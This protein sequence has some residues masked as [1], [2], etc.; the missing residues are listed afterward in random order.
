MDLRGFGMVSSPQLLGMS[1][2]LSMQTPP[3]PSADIPDP[4]GR[5]AISN[6][7]HT[8]LALLRGPER[9]H[10][11]ATFCAPPPVF[12][13]ESGEALNHRKESCERVTASLKAAP[14][15]AGLWLR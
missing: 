3:S 14:A 8:S 2:S 12:T 7:F 11:V 9:L 4:E 6:R 10:S 15:G 5:Q 1:Y 13:A